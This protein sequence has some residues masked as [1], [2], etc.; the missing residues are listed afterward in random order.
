MVGIGSVSSARVRGAM[1]AIR[2]TDG[3]NA[4]DVLAEEAAIVN[5]AAAAAKGTINNAVNTG[6]D[7]ATN[8]TKSRINNLLGGPR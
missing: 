3:M 7:A 5:R 6:I 2:P 4:L 1:G 8:A